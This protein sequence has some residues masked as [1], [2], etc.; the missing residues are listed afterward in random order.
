MEREWNYRVTRLMQCY[1]F[2]IVATGSRV[3][4][5]HAAGRILFALWSVLRNKDS[6]HVP[7]YRWASR[8]R[9]ERGWNYSPILV[10]RGDNHVVI[11]K[12][13]TID[14]NYNLPSD[15]SFWWFFIFLKLRKESIYWYFRIIQFENYTFLRGFSILINQRFKIS[16]IFK[17]FKLRKKMEEI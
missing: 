11:G 17:I 8:T 7:R 13:T 15:E 5:L 6:L 4:G 16:S 3:I 2:D 10:E 1:H 14:V 12:L 9:L